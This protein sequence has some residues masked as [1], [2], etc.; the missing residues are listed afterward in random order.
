MRSEKAIMTSRREF[1]SDALG[2]GLVTASTWPIRADEARSIHGQSDNSTAHSGRT[3]HNISL[4]WDVFLA[5][6]IPAI[7]TNLPPGE[8]DRP[9]PP[10][11]STLLSCHPTPALAAT[12]LPS[13][14]P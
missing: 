7:T 6:S 11:A 3:A 5:P 4:R 9:W 14:P 2:I 1:L 10:I 8:K 12:P 13:P